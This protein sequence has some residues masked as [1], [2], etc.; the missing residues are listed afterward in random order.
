MKQKSAYGAMGA[1]ML[2]LRIAV[3]IINCDHFTFN[4]TAYP[5][6]KPFLIALM[7]FDAVVFGVVVVD[8]A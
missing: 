3:T 5:A 1:A 6:C 7:D 2:Y 8:C 4:P